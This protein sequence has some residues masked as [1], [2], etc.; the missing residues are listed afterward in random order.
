ME[1]LLQLDRELF[2]FI[3]GHYDRVVDFI[4]YYVAQKWIWIPFYLWLLYVLSRNY[5]WKTLWFLPVTALL[6]AGSDQLS[7]L[8]KESFERIRPCHEPLLTGMVHLVKN[9][10]GGMYGFISSHAANTMALAIFLHKML[11]KGYGDIRKELI[12]YVL[13]NGYSRIYLGA[14]YPGDVIGGWMAG[15][16]LGYIF[17]K[18]MQQKLSVP[19]KVAKGHE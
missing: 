7:V 17:A 16:I 6:I 2:L 15:A 8:F 13:L 11:P 9:K 5:G 14:H 3:N 19:L 1:T 12:A 18:L 10:C 4:M